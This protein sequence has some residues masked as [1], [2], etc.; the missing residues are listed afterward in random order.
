MSGFHL[1][2][3]TFDPFLWRDAAGRANFIGQRPT[4]G[5]HRD[6]VWP[7]LSR[8]KRHRHKAERCSP[9]HAR[10]NRSIEAA[11]RLAV[12][13]RWCPCN[14]LEAHHTDACDHAQRPPRYDPW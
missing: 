7:A 14:R 1:E 4:T 10:T 3:A 12:S 8:S 6:R 5:R 2:R 13:R 11:A 9:Q